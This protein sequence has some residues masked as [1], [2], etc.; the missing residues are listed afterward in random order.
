MAYGVKYTMNFRDDRGYLKRIDILQK[1][2]VGAENSMVCTENPLTIEWVDT[3]EY[4]SPIIG[5][6]AT[7]NLM[8][9]DSVDYDNF[10][11]ADERE[12]QLKF[13]VST[14][15]GGWDL[16]WM[17][18]ITTDLYE[19][20]IK[21]KPYTQTIKAI[22]SLGSLDSFD[23][24]K[25]NVQTDIRKSA[26]ELLYQN[27]NYTG[28][29]FNIWLSND[30]RQDGDAEWSNPFE[31]VFL[32]YESNFK[33]KYES[34]TAKEVIENILK[35]F[36]CKI[37]QSYGRFFIVNCSSYGD[38]NTL[39]AIRTGAIS[40]QSAILSYK[41]GQLNANQENIRYEIYNYLG[42]YQSSQTNNN[43]FKIVSS[44]T[45]TANIVVPVNN[46]MIKF[47]KRPIKKYSIEMDLGQKVKD[48]SGNSSFEVYGD[49]FNYSLFWTKVGTFTIDNDSCSGDKSIYHEFHTNGQYYTR[50]SQ[51][52]NYAED[53]AYNFSFSA[54]IIGGDTDTKIPYYIMLDNPNFV[55]NPYYWDGS[56]WTASA[57]IIWNLSGDFND[58]SYK[59]INVGLTEINAYTLNDGNDFIEIH[60]GDT[61]APNQ[62]IYDTVRTYL[63]NVFLENTTNINKFNKVI[64]E[65]IQN[66]ANVYSDVFN[67]SGLLFGDLG[68]RDFYGN[69]YFFKL[70]KRSLDST[71]KVLEQIVTQQ[72]LNDFRDY[73]ENYQFSGTTFDYYPLS[74][75][76]KI[77]LNLT[78]ETES[79]SGIIDT[80]KYDVKKAQMFIKFH[81][82]NNYVDVSSTF[83]SKYQE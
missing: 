75:H 30:I 29:E 66:T 8:V 18:W 24:W 74:M 73:V 42:V 39:D 27:I 47:F 1:D 34:L 19:I 33:N 13:Y 58:Y 50:L 43:L 49:G 41:Q 55:S 46:D 40:G 80:I 67:E 20:A 28:L 23:S 35:S 16:Y 71:G 72:R 61:Y 12:Y 52:I 53:G 9:T 70:F 59:T 57:S 48:V 11:L 62:T 69:Y 17:G 81:I 44:K 54:K 6:V 37:F 76:N 21:S 38:E 68:N 3:N 4:Y 14:S 56:Q 26:W 15:L 51:Q 25:Y 5:S 36:N 77:Y 32:P 31:D 45:P 2:Y 82:P 83:R 60:I 7:L 64:F 22:D 65:N 79:D 10:Y 63:D 78:Q